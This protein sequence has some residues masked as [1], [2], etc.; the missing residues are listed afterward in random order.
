MIT[1]EAYVNA[2][3]LW[4]SVLD[5]IKE[6]LKIIPDHQLGWW[7]NFRIGFPFF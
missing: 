1:T 4:I 6:K 7:Q 5:E 3:L 2:T